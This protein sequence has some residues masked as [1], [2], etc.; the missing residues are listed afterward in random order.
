VAD[1]FERVVEEGVAP[2]EAANWIAGELFRRMKAAGQD[3]GELAV[4][5]EALARLIKLVEKGTINQTTGKDVLGEMLASGREAQDIVREQALAQISDIEE[6]ERI[7]TQ[8]LDESPD[9]VVEYL[10]GKE[11]VLGWFIG[12]VMRATGGKANPQLARELLKDKVEARR[13]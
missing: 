7:V 3:S 2:K 11:Q 8:V 12:R 13:G 6:L 1:Y 10:S 9:Q 4:S 5:P